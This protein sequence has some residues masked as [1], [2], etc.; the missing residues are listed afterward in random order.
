MSDR[1]S[2][3]DTLVQ[4]A[5]DARDEAGRALAEQQ[6]ARQQAGQQLESLHRYRAEYTDQL[7]AAMN[8]G[9]DPATLRNYH[10]FIGSLDDATVRARQSLARQDQRVEQARQKWQRETQRLAS[11][12]ALIERRQAA[13]RRE[14]QRREQRI[15]DDLVNG[16]MARQPSPGEY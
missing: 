5:R 8:G 12:E 10:Q 13:E 4:L 9:I 11:Y 7:N 3:L 15:S 6:R 1:D 14:E 2:S 16:R